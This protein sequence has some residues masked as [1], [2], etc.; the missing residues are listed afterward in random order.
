MGIFPEKML[1]YYSAEDG[2]SQELQSLIGALLP[3]L[4]Q[5]GMSESLFYQRSVYI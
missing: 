5:R 2:I 3:S 4:L 1:G